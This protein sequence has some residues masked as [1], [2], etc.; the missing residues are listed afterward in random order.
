MAKY[1]MI[2]VTVSLMPSGSLAV[3]LIRLNRISRYLNICLVEFTNHQRKP[4]VASS[5][6][7][8]GLHNACPF[9]ASF[10]HCLPTRLSNVCYA[11]C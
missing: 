5:D 3:Y 7:V 6:E 1:I 9:G 8:L 11:I 10:V 2:I 4:R